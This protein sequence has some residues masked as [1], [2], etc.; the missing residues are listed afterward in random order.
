MKSKS[1]NREID[2]LCY[3]KYVVK[4]ETEKCNLDRVH[5]RTT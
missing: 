1:I 2:A 3:H 4:I 5:Y